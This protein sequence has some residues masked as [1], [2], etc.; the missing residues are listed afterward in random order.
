[1]TKIKLLQSVKYDDISAK[2]KAKKEINASGKAVLPG[3]VNAH[4]HAVLILLRGG[5]SQDRNLYDWLIN[6]LCPGMSVFNANDAKVAA[7]LFCV[8]SIK[9]GSTT[10]ADN[11]GRGDAE[12]MAAN[13]IDTYIK[14]GLRAVYARMFNDQ[15]THDHLL[16]ACKLKEP[17]IKH[18]PHFVAVEDTNEALK[19]IESLMNKYNG[20]GNGRISVWPLPGISSF[21]KEEGLLGALELAKKH[22]VMV[23]THIA[24]TA[25]D[26]NCCDVSMAQYLAN[27]GYLNSRLLAG[28]CVWMTDKDLYLLKMFDVKVA[29]L[30]VSN[31]YL[32]SGVAPVVK[33]IH[34]G[35]TV[36]LGTD[37]A[38]CNDSF[39]M[40]TDMKQAALIQKAVNLDASVITAEKILE[41]ANIDGAKAIGMEDEIGSIE[42]G[43]KAEI[44]TVNLEL[45]HLK[46]C[47]HIPSTL[48][49]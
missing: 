19:S 26:A 17:D 5:L 46:P 35:I 40:F 21:V 34:L 18:T 37:D 47:H 14:C 16:H 6:V 3:L 43:K 30:A 45:P 32:G 41:M 11:A 23:S 24:E 8:E 27:I 10:F 12:V 33:M 20:A 4:T 9:R 38:N 36:G 13:T 28:H 2:Y 44:I 48:V 49:Y 22:D 42:V 1:M 31:Q 7:K 25:Y 29:N 39:N 15:K